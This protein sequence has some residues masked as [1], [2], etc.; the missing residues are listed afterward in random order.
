MIRE[1]LRFVTFLISKVGH[2][3]HYAHLSL[4]F[5]F[6]FCVEADADW[7]GLFTFCIV[8]EFC[9]KFM[10]IAAQALCLMCII[11]HK[12]EPICSFNRTLSELQQKT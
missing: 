9:A 4:H 11:L 6:G 10:Q 12:D 8:L 5:R 2:F 1:S 3:T 7:F